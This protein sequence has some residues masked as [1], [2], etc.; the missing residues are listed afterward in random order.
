MNAL[1]SQA[2]AFPNFP[3][4]VASALSQ[5]NV[6]LRAAGPLAKSTTV[7]FRYVKALVRCSG[8]VDYL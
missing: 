7:E 5:Q 3:E 4:K 6:C 2:N 1:V 8:A